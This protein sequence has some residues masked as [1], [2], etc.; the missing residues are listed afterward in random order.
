MINKQKKR[1]FFIY[2]MM[3][4]IIALI[5]ARTIISGKAF[6]FRELSTPSY[7]DVLIPLFVILLGRFGKVNRGIQKALYISGGYLFF[8]AL[9]T[10]TFKFAFRNNVEHPNQFVYLIFGAS[11]CAIF[12]LGYYLVKELDNK[13]E[14]PPEPGKTFKIAYILLAVAFFAFAFVLGVIYIK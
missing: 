3:L 7:N 14:E 8:Y 12:L 13:S 4:L 11:F 9:L 2:F 6:L 10:Y 5:P 1:L